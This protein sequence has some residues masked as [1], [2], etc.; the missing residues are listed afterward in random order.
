MSVYFI[1]SL[2]RTEEEHGS[3]KTGTYIPWGISL[4]Y[5]RI[6]ENMKTRKL[7]DLEYVRYGHIYGVFHIIAWL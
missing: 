1:G 5:V 7:C 6:L 4:G 2:S 3:H